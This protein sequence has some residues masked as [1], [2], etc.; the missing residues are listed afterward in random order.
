VEFEWDRD[1][2]ASNAKKHRVPFAEAMTVFAD[3]LEIINAREAT[4]QER[5]QYESSSKQ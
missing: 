1:K 5:K 2:A 3:P 4:S